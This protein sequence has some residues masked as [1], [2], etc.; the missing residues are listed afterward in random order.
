MKR[1]GT[2]LLAAALTLSLAACGG[3]DKQPSRESSASIPPS[4]ANQPAPSQAPAP[5]E[6]PTPAPADPGEVTVEETVLLDEEGIKITATALDMDSLFGPEVKV[7]IENNSDT[8]VTVQTRHSSVNGYMVETMMSADVVA[9]KKAV[10]SITL[11]STELEKCGIE[12]V[13]DMELS[14][15][16]FTSEGWDTVLDTPQIRLET[17]A[18]AGYGYSYD[19]EGEVLYEGNGIKMVNRGL[20]TESSI[21]GPSLMVMIQNDTDRGITVQ[22]RDT[23]V[24]GLMM[25]PIFSEEV[26]PGK[27]AVGDMTFMSSSL[28]DSGIEE[29]EELEFSFHIFS[30]DG[31]DAIADTDPIT[32]TFAQ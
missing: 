19:M 14:F 2:L 28:E 4:A 31:W 27:Y 23:S 29:I 18:A 8:D 21:M 16:I 12:T 11:M 13:A 1:T 24:N 3:S 17:S 9:G 26:M 15:H 32:V 7:L 30:T 20:D 10:D 22:A 5:T 25:D 6:A